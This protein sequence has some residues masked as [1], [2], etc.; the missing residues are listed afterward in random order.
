M[1]KE[2]ET[3]RNPLTVRQ[4]HP[5]EPQDHLTGPQSLQQAMELQNQATMRR[6]Q[7]MALQSHPMV[8]QGLDSLHLVLGQFKCDF[9]G[10]SIFEWRKN[11]IL[12]PQV[13]SAVEQYRTRLL[14]CPPT[15]QLF[16]TSEPGTAGWTRFKSSWKYLLQ[17]IE[18][19]A[20]I[21]WLRRWT[22]KALWQVKMWED[23]QEE[24]K[25]AT[26][27]RCVCLASPKSSTLPLH[28]IL[29]HNHNSSIIM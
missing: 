13:R 3:V 18:S 25:S 21:K 23:P 17:Q 1:E 27:H 4:N 29:I 8:S 10:I 14:A 24:E 15:Q 12:Y 7:T 20:I 19:L 2:T 9:V 6:L 16:P 5:T 11:Q 28:I 22:L 26:A